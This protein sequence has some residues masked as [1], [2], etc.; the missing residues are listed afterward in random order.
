MAETRGILWQPVGFASTVKTGA[1]K[2]PKATVVG[3]HLWSLEAHK[4]GLFDPL[5]KER[6][7]KSRDGN[8]LRAFAEECTIFFKE[9]LPGILEDGEKDI[10][11]YVGPYPIPKQLKRENS[12]WQEVGI[13]WTYSLV[14][15]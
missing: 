14:V 8:N 13:K 2:R 7:G 12:E 15:S 5:P 3:I 4:L 11:F 1:F 6:K 9:Q 10:L